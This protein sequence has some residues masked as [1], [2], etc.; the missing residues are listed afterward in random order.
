MLA[1]SV[2]INGPGTDS[3]HPDFRMEGDDVR[4][5][6]LEIHSLSTPTIVTLTNVGDVPVQILL[7]DRDFV[8]PLSDRGF[9]DFESAR[10][11]I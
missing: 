2:A 10:W 7:V 1:I 5:D 4:L 6:I 8:E 11:E 3:E 9:I